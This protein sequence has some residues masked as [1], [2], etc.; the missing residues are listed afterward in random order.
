MAESRSL[1][2]TET[3]Y[4]AESTALLARLTAPSWLV[5]HPV[6]AMPASAKPIAAKNE[7]ERD[8]LGKRFI[9]VH[10]CHGPSDRAAHHRPLVTS[11]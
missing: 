2:A 8:A 11:V 10:L 9:I 3:W 1:A 7:L 4:A 5:V 6:R